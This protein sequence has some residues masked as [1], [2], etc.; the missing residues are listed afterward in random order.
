M[1]TLVDLALFVLPA[2][3]VRFAVRRSTPAK[4]LKRTPTAVI[5]RGTNR[6]RFGRFWSSTPQRVFSYAAAACLPLAARQ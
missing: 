4:R 6:Q 2:L 5:D 3:Y 1:P